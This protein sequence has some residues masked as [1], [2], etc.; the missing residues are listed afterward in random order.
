MY[1]NP[2]KFR[3][4]GNAPISIAN[5]FQS[6]YENKTDV[7]RALRRIA[8]PAQIL[9]VFPLNVN[10]TVRI[11]VYLSL[12]TVIVQCAVGYFTVVSA[13]RI[14]FAGPTAAVVEGEKSENEPEDEAFDFSSEAANLSMLFYIVFSTS[15]FCWYRESFEKIIQRIFVCKMLANRTGRRISIKPNWRP[16]L[17][18]IPAFS[19]FVLDYYFTRS[20][21]TKKELVG[22]VCEFLAVSVVIFFAQLVLLVREFL[23]DLNRQLLQIMAQLDYPGRYKKVS[24]LA[25]CH[26]HLCR[27]CGSINSVHSFPLAV[28]YFSIFIKLIVVIFA[29]VHMLSSGVD[30]E[31][32]VSQLALAS[33]VG[34]GWY[35]T[36]ICAKTVEQVPTA[37]CFQIYYKKK[38]NITKTE[39]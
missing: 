11:S 4:F 31:F 5:R 21:L 18:Q 23:A 14:F 3:K 1:Q 20:G 12:F 9:G 22:Y 36:H 28:L 33:Y 26:H 10:E 32:A 17:L 16:A 13:G 15:S 38:K 29:G 19:A 39:K 25:D 8:L 2:S 35:L 27:A 34:R 6:I 30:L 24:I 7:R 37:N